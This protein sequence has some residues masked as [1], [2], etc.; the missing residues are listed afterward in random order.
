MMG[1]KAKL[2][3]DSNK[4]NSNNNNSVQQIMKVSDNN[5]D[6]Q[7]NESDNCHVNNTE[8]LQQL[9]LTVKLK[10]NTSVPDHI[11]TDQVMGSSSPNN[12]TDIP[13]KMDSH[14]SRTDVSAN[15]VPTSTFDAV[16]ETPECHSFV[17]EGQT[18]NITLSV[19]ISVQEKPVS[20]DS[21]I[22]YFLNGSWGGVTYGRY[23]STSLHRTFRFWHERCILF[24]T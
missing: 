24:T 7:C 23:T 5:N 20:H 14:V 18:D 3:S 17:A 16:R 9:A 22:S 1:N 2:S 15:I 6:Q 21:R 12:V 13:E 10:D 11:C 19:S 4:N 8:L